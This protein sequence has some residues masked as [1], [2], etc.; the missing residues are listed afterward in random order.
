MTSVWCLNAVVWL[1]VANGRGTVC[2]V[3]IANGFRKCLP[4]R[5]FVSQ[6]L[7]ASGIG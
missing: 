2:I 4:N 5:L 6:I 1:V 7:S 3:R